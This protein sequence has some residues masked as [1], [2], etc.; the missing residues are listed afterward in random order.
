MQIS[1]S[2]VF[3]LLAIGVGFSIWGFSMLI[4]ISSFRCARRRVR[5]LEE[6]QPM[7][8]LPPPAFVLHLVRRAAGSRLDATERPHCGRILDLIGHYSP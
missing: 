5:D 2:R 3:M 4:V 8:P 1:A 7:P 6:S